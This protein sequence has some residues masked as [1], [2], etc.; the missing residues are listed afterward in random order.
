MANISE[1][2][3]LSM[4]YNLIK[5]KQKA[6]CVY[7]KGDKAYG[8]IG[9]QLYIY[10]DTWIPYNEDNSIRNLANSIMEINIEAF[11]QPF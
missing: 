4:A 11:W 7:D 5:G 9:N 10:E 8:L 1:K 3:C 2:N 6:I